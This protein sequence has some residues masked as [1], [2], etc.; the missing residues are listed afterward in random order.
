[1]RIK[2]I[3]FA[4]GI[5]AAS[6]SAGCAYAQVD[7]RVGTDGIPTGSRTSFDP[8]T[9]GVHAGRFDPFTEGLHGSLPVTAQ[10]QRKA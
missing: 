1:M 2:H 5:A 7:A 4:I 9:D 3:G 8:F 10:I 6:L